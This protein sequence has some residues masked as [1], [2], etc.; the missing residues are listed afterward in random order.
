[1]TSGLLKSRMTVPVK[2]AGSHVGSAF[3]VG[4]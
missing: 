4:K 3:F 1:L 2:K